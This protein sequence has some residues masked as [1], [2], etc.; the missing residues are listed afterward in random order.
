MKTV[1]DLR[2]TDDQH[3]LGHALMPMIQSFN[4]ELP[5]GLCWEAFESLLDDLER[6]A[7]ALV[8]QSAQASLMQRL[9]ARLFGG[10]AAVRLTPTAEAYARLDGQ[11]AALRS[12]RAAVADYVRASIK[13][14][15]VSIQTHG[16]EVRTTRPPRPGSS[17]M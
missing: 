10:E 7:I 16:P 14:K 12:V 9:V 4:G 2:V 13:A 8:G 5:Q 6:R 17:P 11:L 3:A 1:Y 15:P